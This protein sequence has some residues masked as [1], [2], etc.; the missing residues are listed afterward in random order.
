M[1]TLSG[2]AYEFRTF[3]VLYLFASIRMQTFLS[4]RIL[5]TCIL[6]ALVYPVISGADTGPGWR[7]AFDIMPANWAVQG[8]P[9]TKAAVFQI[10]ADPTNAAL[11]WLSMTADQSSASLKTSD[12]VP[13][14]LNKAPIMRWCWRAT[15]LPTGA[16][17]RD[18][19][20]DDQAIG[21]Y[22]S[23]GGLF[24]QQS[25]AYR[26]ET[27]TPV[28]TEGDAQYAKVVR[29]HWLALRNKNDVDGKTFYIEERNVAEDYRKAFG[30]VPDK[31]G[32][33]ISC[34]SQY[35]ASQA[36]AQLE[37]IEFLPAG[38]NP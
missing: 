10:A 28:G 38:T 8:K 11:H 18:P 12:S 17:G 27:E 32:I 20:K 29:V 1:K 4:C 35:T 26:W 14:D 16:D 6:A 19:K 21:L 24:K 31:I 25:I 33:G 3:S 2:R 36:D 13:V 9:F 5:P 22:I 37:W 23:S 15:T 30:S 34:N 7:L